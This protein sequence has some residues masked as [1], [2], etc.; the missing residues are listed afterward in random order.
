MQQ[1]KQLEQM[2]PHKSAWIFLYLFFLFCL[3]V[4]AVDAL[5]LPK[6][7]QVVAA[8]NQQAASDF[9]LNVSFL[10]AFLAGILTL[11]SPCLL[12]LVPAYFSIVFKEKNQIMK[13]TLIFFAGFSGMFLVLGML[14]TFLGTESIIL[15][16]Q[17]NSLYIQVAGIIMIFFGILALAGVGFSGLLIRKKL[18]HDSWG[19]FVYGIL[20]A[21]GWTGC[22]GPILAGVLSMTAVFHNYLT[23]ALFMFFYSLGIFVPLFL[24]SYWYDSHHLEKL[25]WMKG[26]IW[27]FTFHGKTHSVHTSNLISGILFIFLGILFLVTKGTGIFNNVGYFGIKQLFYDLQR[28]LLQGGLVWN[29][30]GGVVFLGIIYFIWRGLKIDREE[31]Q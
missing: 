13:M 21:L 18:T 14:A 3:F 15:L 30:V 8:Y 17:N 23:G 20:F 6:G 26:S 24:V 2:A 29:I 22:M 11:L 16:Q 31:V 9:L 1:Q 19:V 12:P 4:T 25:K 7:L 10:I 28:V 27:H 5:T